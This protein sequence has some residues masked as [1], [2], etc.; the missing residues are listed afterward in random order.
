M[1]ATNRMIS[2]SVI[3]RVL[4]GSITLNNLQ[5]PFWRARIATSRINSS[6]FSSP[7]GC[8]S[9]ISRLFLCTYSTWCRQERFDCL[10]FSTSRTVTIFVVQSQ[11]PATDC[12]K[13]IAPVCVCET[14][15][16]ERLDPL[17]RLAKTWTR[18]FFDCTQCS[19]F[20]HRETDRRDRPPK[21]LVGVI[22]LQ[23]LTRINLLMQAF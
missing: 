12:L 7:V 1:S 2:R 23:Y 15:L 19:R 14:P 13:I 21:P 11:V 6:V 16:T 5:L 9:T 22:G 17:L 20:I 10:G 8:K 4:F 3:V 18:P